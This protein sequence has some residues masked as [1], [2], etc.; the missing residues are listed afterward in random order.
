M[1]MPHDIEQGLRTTKLTGEDLALSA[2]AIHDRLE[3]Y[4]NG[5]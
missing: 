1:K 5:V 2:F 3:R 4:Y